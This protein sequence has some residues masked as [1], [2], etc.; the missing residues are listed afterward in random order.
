MPDNPTGAGPGEACARLAFEARTHMRH[1][2]VAATIDACL[3]ALRSEDVPLEQAV[4]IEKLLRQAD[5]TDIA[6]QIRGHILTGLDQIEHTHGDDPLARGNIANILV[7]MDEHEKALA[8]LD[9]ARAGASDDFDILFLQLVCQLETGRFQSGR[10]DVALISNGAER[11]QAVV[12]ALASLLAHYGELDEARRILDTMAHT[13]ADSDDAA[14]LATLRGA[15]DGAAEP[16]EQRGSTSRLFD[17]F[18]DSYDQ[19]LAALDN[20]G[21]AM[22]GHML[23]LIDLP[24]DGSRRV[25][26][27]GCGTG[28]CEPW[29]RPRA[30]LLHGADLSIGMLEKC[31]AK[32][33]YDLLCRSDLAAAD[34]LPD[35]TFDLVVSADVLVYF[36]NLGNVFANIA[37]MLAPG[38]WFV[39][40]VEEAAAGIA[41]PGYGLNLSG[42]N[43]HGETYLRGAL[44]AAGFEVRRT[45]RDTLRLEFRKP[46]AGLA[47]AAQKVG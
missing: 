44:A 42:R 12:V 21:P 33:S 40:T 24:R 43:C 22:I 47:V 31:R 38:G 5:A 7:L 30:S 14:R 41:P 37:A 3:R 29:L 34:T 16:V 6:D 27:A 19:K 9:L 26:D 8:H 13:F 28:L 46:V 15:M 4:G 18:A 1:G 17:S 45:Y 39:F 32:G 36:G 2:D 35:G 25:F 11:P 10:L 20:N 23:D